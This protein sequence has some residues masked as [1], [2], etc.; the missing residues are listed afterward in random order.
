MRPKGHLKVKAIMSCFFNRRKLHTG[1][2]VYRQT[3]FQSSGI[4]FLE[5]T[6]GTKCSIPG[7]AV[8]MAANNSFNVPVL[9]LSTALE[10][11]GTVPSS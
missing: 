6:V 4:G 9:V 7:K 11:Q 10:I 2:P 3:D 5:L 1:V 8:E